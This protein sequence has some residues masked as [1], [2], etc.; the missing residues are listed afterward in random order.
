VIFVLSDSTAANNATQLSFRETESQQTM[1]ALHVHNQTVVH[2]DNPLKRNMRRRELS[3][4]LSCGG[5]I[6]GHCRRRDQRAGSL[7]FCVDAAAGQLRQVRISAL[8]V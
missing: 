3:R 1:P 8:L 7:D 6:A 5:L 2:A 4:E